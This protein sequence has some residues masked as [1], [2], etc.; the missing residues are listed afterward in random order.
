[1]RRRVN[2]GRIRRLIGK[3]LRAGVMEDGVLTHPEKGFVQQEVRR[4][5]DLLERCPPDE[6]SLLPARIE[7]CDPRFDEL[8]KLLWVDLFDDWDK[9]VSAIRKAIE[10]RPAHMR[11]V[12]I[13]ADEVQ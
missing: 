10:K 4:A 8:R 2:D 6:I 5:L 7:A 1:M 12:K 11:A 9:G 13:K 3:W